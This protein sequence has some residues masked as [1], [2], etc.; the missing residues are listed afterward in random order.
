MFKN[1]FRYEFEDV[2]CH[3]NPP[4]PISQRL[5][6]SLEPNDYSEAET[7]LMEACG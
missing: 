1:I 3:I 6:F 4:I 7:K 2:L 5:G